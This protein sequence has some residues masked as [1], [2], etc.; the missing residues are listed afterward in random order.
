MADMFPPF[1][2]IR[3]CAFIFHER[4]NRGWHVPAIWEH[5]EMRISISWGAQSCLISSCHFWLSAGAYSHFMS[6][7]I[8]ADMFSPLLTFRRCV[9]PFHT[10]FMSYTRNCKKSSFL[11]YF[12]ASRACTHF[13]H[14]VM[15]LVMSLQ[16]ASITMIQSW[17]SSGVWRYE[18]QLCVSQF[19]AVGLESSLPIVKQNQ[20]VRKLPEQEGC[21]E[22]IQERILV[23]YIQRG[24]RMIMTAD[25]VDTILV[26]WVFFFW[27]TY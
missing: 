12:R 21:I 24:G 13:N 25:T 15:S 10:H 5:Q 19:S 14:P 27:A 23:G 9:C 11:F 2:I 22:E 7:S 1:L 8:M 18:L 6:C 26:P 17:K 16:R 20:I 4:H 3:K